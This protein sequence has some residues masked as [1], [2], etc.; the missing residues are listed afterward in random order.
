MINNIYTSTTHYRSGEPHNALNYTSQGCWLHFL[1]VN[2]SCHNTANWH[3]PGIAYCMQDVHNILL[4][5]N[6]DVIIKPVTGRARICSASLKPTCTRR[7]NALGFTKKKFVNIH[8]PV[9]Q[10]RFTQYAQYAAIYC[11]TQYIGTGTLKCIELYRTMS[12]CNIATY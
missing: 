12:Y 7:L 9:I 4:Y 1:H 2:S 10:F 8:I 5:C 6:T 3:T 11:S